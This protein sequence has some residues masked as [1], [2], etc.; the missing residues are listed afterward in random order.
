MKSREELAYELIFHY[1]A[2][3]G[4]PSSAIAALYTVLKVNPASI[5]P[6]AALAL[7]A[8]TGIV[9]AASAEENSIPAVSKKKDP[10]SSSGEFAEVPEPAAAL[11]GAL[12]V[13]LLLRRRR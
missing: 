4:R 13:M 6:I 9:G 10:M 12:G 3:L 5:L 7:F 1:Q 8:A 11:L 2:C